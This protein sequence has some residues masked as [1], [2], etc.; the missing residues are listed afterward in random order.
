MRSARYPI[1]D[2]GGLS[3]LSHF[4]RA[5]G[6]GCHNGASYGFPKGSPR[7]RIGARLA[8][9]APSPATAA[10][11][12]AAPRAATSVPVSAEAVVLIDLETGK[13]L[14]RRT[15][16]R[17]GAG[18]PREDDDPL[19]RLRGAPRRNVTRNEPDDRAQRDTD[20]A[21]PDRAHDGAGR[22]VRDAARGRR[23]RVGERRGDRG[24]RA[25]RG[26]R[27]EVRRAHE[28]RGRAARLTTRCSPIRTGFPTPG[29]A[30]PR[31]HGGAGG[32]PPAGLPESRVLL[33]DTTSPGA[34]ASS[35]V[36]SRC[37]GTRAA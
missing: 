8:L 13:V 32:A 14:Y 21:L 20:A 5:L 18:Q 33:G 28:R 34:G 24:R 26:E 35:G 22:P 6:S 23:D 2:P 17:T 37:S 4:V 31:G 12:G 30:R 7:G 19:H 1:T 16:R 36:A 25:S 11:Q 15:P 10:T 3:G 27:A 29:S 9:A